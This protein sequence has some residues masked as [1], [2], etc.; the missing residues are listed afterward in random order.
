[1]TVISASTAD[2]QNPKVLR[3]LSAHLHLFLQ[4]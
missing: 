3:T 1:M 2:Q 4:Q